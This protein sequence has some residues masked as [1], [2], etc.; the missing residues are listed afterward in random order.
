MGRYEDPGWGKFGPVARNQGSQMTSTAGLVFSVNNGAMLSFY[1]D[2]QILD[3][4][5]LNHTRRYIST[6]AMDHNF[7]MI[8]NKGVNYLQMY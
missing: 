8:K 3:Y 1:N 5:I 6:R 2:L 7:K 4:N